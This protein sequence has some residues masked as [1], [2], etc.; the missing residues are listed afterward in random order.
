MHVAGEVSAFPQMFDSEYLA[1]VQIGT[2]PQTLMLDFDTGS[3]DLWVFSS[4]TP[5]IQ[6]NGQKLYDI[7]ASTSARKLANQQWDITYGDGSS[8]Q[9]DV[10][11]DTV[12][13]NGVTVIG[14]AVES[15]LQVS[16]SFSNDTASSGLLGLGFDTINQVKPLQQ[17]TFFSNIM[18]ALAMPLFTANLKAGERM[19]IL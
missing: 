6:Q 8:S 3:S 14:Q 18:D 13:L 12:T 15:A 19:C 2:P 1:P 11:L 16:D 4:E 9:G 7:A 17:R 5:K 10:W